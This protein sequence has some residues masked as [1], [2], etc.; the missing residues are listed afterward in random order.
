MPKFEVIDGAVMDAPPMAVFKA[1]LD[2]YSGVTH[3]WMPDL[4]F[5]PRAGNPM[6]REGSICDTTVRGHGMVA[7]FS[8]KV[9]KIEPGKSLD[10]DMTGDFSGT[11]KWTFELTDGK[12]KVQVAWNGASHKLILSLVSPFVHVD[13]ELH[14]SRRRFLEALDNSVRKK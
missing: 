5:K 14:K 12:T 1:V 4:E 13:G 3:L 11:E 9:T 7:K 10:F 2:E 6:D 8:E